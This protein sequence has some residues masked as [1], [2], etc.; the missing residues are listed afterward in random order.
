MTIMK[1]IILLKDEHKLCI[2]EELIEL[3]PKV[4]EVLEYL[5]NNQDRYISINELHDEVWAGVLVSDAAVRRCISKLRQA[6]KD[7]PKQPHFIQHVSKR[8]Y[9]LVC[10]ANT[11]KTTQC[12]SQGHGNHQ[13]SQWQAKKSSHL[14]PYL[15]LLALPL[16]ALF[17]PL[18]QQTSISAQPLVQTTVGADQLSFAESTSGLSAYAAKLNGEQDYSIILS[19]QGTGT[20][21][22]IMEN[23]NWPDAMAFSHS[24]ERLFISDVV[25][26]NS[27]II[28]YN[29]QTGQTR[30]IID[31]QFL[32][33]DIFLGP[34]EDTL[35]FLGASHAQSAFHLYQYSHKT[36]T[37][38]AVI[39]NAESYI[40]FFAGAVS[41]Q[42]DKIALLVFDSL[43][44]HSY[45][46]IYDLRSLQRIGLVPHSSKLI[47]L[48]WRD[49]NTLLIATEQ[50]VIE[51][52]LEQQMQTHLADD[53]VYMLSYQPQSQQLHM[54]S[55]LKKGAFF[56]E[57]TLPLNSTPK[58]KLY[59]FDSD[60][61]SLINISDDGS[62]IAK[63]QHQDN[64][65]IVKFQSSMPNK[66]GVLL[67]ST[68]KLTDLS[69]ARKAQAF[70]VKQDKT[71]IKVDYT[72]SSPITESI[73]HTATPHSVVIAS[74][75][76]AVY[77][78]AKSDSQWLVYRWEHNELTH[79]FSGFKFVREFE[80][81]LLLAN[82]EGELFIKPKDASILPLHTRAVL[83]SNSEIQLYEDLVIWTEHD[84][85]RVSYHQLDISKTEPEHKKFELPY[86]SSA[87]N[88]Y[89]S[90]RNNALIIKKDAQ[91]QSS[92]LMAQVKVTKKFTLNYLL[93]ALEM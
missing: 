3:E 57:L 45:I 80:G 46:E 78:T 71:I 56:L 79:L 9:K 61:Q 85:S 37:I 52:N 93:E 87:T 41:T 88:F 76:K 18:S 33:A 65:Q 6:F 38:E 35:Y 74:D 92:Q 86:D 25:K 62:F 10:N 20:E 22:V 48:D 68:D 30:H 2:E 55:E 42:Q 26:G 44:E 47:D 69:H 11:C 58:R 50:G 31:P 28:E 90:N 81:N 8:G 89:I 17:V 29:I 54:L 73:R 53:F 34:T 91:T 77:F 23:V 24:G 66:K 82:I 70:A 15:L 1:R 21:S 83:E 7:D 32:I 60:I 43:A 75:G 27:T 36:G 13:C 16:L 40:N 63:I 51:H 84:L 59:H 72:H 49:N 19:N 14:S 12:P 39:K 67:Q 64:T 4:F 5:Y